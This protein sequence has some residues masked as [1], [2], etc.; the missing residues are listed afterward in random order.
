MKE[1]SPNKQKVLL[2]LLAGAALGLSYSP[3]RHGRILK[4]LSREWKNIDQRRLRE[5]IRELYRSKLIETRTNEDG[6]TTLLLT[7]KGKARALTYKFTE[8]HIT[9]QKWNGQWHMVVADI[10]EK[11]GK[12]KTR[13][14]RDAL[15]R[16]LLQLGFYPL[17]ETV[18]VIPWPCEQEIEFIV[19]YFGLRKYVRYGILSYI[20]NDLHLRKIYDLI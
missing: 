7:N 13:Q 14:T 8:M 17:Q 2:L 20:D 18:W 16:K 10:P 15:R 4:S 9:K 3:G 5:E 1:L 12:T 11:L 6:S 19:E